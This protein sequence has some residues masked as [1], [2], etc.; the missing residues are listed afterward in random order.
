LA[1]KFLKLNSGKEQTRNYETEEPR[2]KMDM[3]D[4][5]Y[6]FLFSQVMKLELKLPDAAAEDRFNSFN[7]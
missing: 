1:T 5:F 3:A 7:R 4:E 6:N 2:T